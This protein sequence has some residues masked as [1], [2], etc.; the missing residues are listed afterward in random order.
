MV[1][2][3]SAAL[4]E[5]AER[6]VG[7][8]PALLARIPEQPAAELGRLGTQPESPPEPGPARPDPARQGEVPVLAALH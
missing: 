7:S 5:L 6:V 3:S 8:L 2:V 4:S 1:E